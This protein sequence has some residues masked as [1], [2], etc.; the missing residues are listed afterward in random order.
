M[1]PRIAIYGGTFDPIHYGHLRPVEAIAEKMAIDQVELIPC[2]VS[3][4]KSATTASAEQR[5]AMASLAVESFPRFHVNDIEIKQHAPSF[6]IDTVKHFKQHAYQVFMF[7]GMDSLNQFHK[8]HQYQQ[9]LALANIIVCQR[10]GHALSLLN[11]TQRLLNQHGVT[12]LATFLRV[13]AGAIYIAQNPQVDVAATDIRA[14]LNR[15]Q[16][17]P[18]I[19]DAVAQYIAKHQLYRHSSAKTDTL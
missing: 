8:W 11:D 10:P 5:I 7:I 2:Y 15:G 1:V 3:P 16:S 9:I 4:H 6:S 12:D 14:R 19:P 13:P 18:L 17:H